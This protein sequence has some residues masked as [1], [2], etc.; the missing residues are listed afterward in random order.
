MAKL[1]AMYEESMGYSGLM[2]LE[3]ESVWER[4]RCRFLQPLWDMKLAEWS[5]I[6]SFKS[7]HV[8]VRTW[9]KIGTESKVIGQV[10]SRYYYWDNHRSSL[11]VA[12]QLG[13]Y[14]LLR[15]ID[16]LK[17]WVIS[18]FKYRV[19]C[20]RQILS[21][22]EQQ[23]KGGHVL[24][25]LDFLSCS[26]HLHW[27]EFQQVP[28]KSLDVWLLNQEFQSESTKLAERVHS[29]TKFCE[30]MVP[31][32]WATSRI[33]NTYLTYDSGASRITSASCTFES[34]RFSNIGYSVSDKYYTGNWAANQRKPRTSTWYD[35][36]FQPPSSSFK[37]RRIAL[38]LLSA[39]AQ[40]D[41]WP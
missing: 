31:I 7:I 2:A 12:A 28:R 16:K 22:A 19:V 1:L 24:V 17:I 26:W 34:F 39:L 37:L 33:S 10:D 35:L 6:E 38:Q 27:V 3:S 13:N 40:L 11:L 18:L 14:E 29:I 8:V 32:A 4:D 5:Y 23:I 30:I 36:F 15:Q 41:S 20:F 9:L 21:S 25:L